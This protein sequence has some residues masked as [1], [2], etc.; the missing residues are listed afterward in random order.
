MLNISEMAK[1]TAIV[2]WIWMANKKLYPYR[3][4]KWYHFEWPWVT[5]KPDFKVTILL[6]S[7][8]STIS[9]SCMIYQL[10]T[11]PMTQW[12][13][14]LISRSRVTIGLDAFDVLCVQWTH[15]LFA[16]AKSC[17]FT[18]NVI[19]SIIVEHIWSTYVEL[20]FPL[21]AVVQQRKLHCVILLCRSIA[22][23]L[24]HCCQVSARVECFK[25]PFKCIPLVA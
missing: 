10:V 8:D 9:K 14:T 13:L 25:W 12:P 5:S 3:T 19:S 21:K 6:T 16:I 7:N 20:Q 15:D 11:F 24:L 2:T 18:F 17:L 23:T 1:A 4:F 22:W